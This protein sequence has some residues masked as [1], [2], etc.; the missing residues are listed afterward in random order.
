MGARQ[1]KANMG[2]EGGGSKNVDMVGKTGMEGKGISND[3]RRKEKI[4]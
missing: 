4:V 3:K 2:R 1:E